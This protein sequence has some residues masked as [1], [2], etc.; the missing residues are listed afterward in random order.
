MH[1]SDATLALI[2]L[3]C[4]PDA[5]LNVRRTIAHIEEAAAKGAQI[6]CLQELFANPYVAQRVTPR[7][8][9]LAESPDSDVLRAMADL[10]GKLGV[11]LIVP[12]YEKAGRG[13]YYNSAAVYDADG[14]CLGTT[15]KNHIPDGPQY[16]EK[17]YFIPGNTGYPVYKTAFGT[18]GIGICWDEWFPETARLLALQGAEILFFPSAIGSEPDHPELSTRRTWEKAISAHGIHNGV[19]IAAVNRVG[20]EDDMTFY[21]GSFVSNPMGDIVQSLDDEE[22][23]LIQKVELG[24][25]DFARNLLQ[26]MRDRR[27]ETY[28]MLMTRDSRS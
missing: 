12:Y 3:S 20:R 8:Y 14:T 7:G 21:G 19:F 15:R 2:Q 5:A 26:F 22:G 25:I 11:V 28:G 6:I 1:Q 16:H 17:Y 23:I 10:A 27:P 18:I 9:E 4:D 13:L 24:E